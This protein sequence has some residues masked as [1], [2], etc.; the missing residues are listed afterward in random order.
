MNPGNIEEQY[1]KKK[2][3]INKIDKNFLTQFQQR[4]SIDQ[5]N[6]THERKQQK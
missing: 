3:F 5:E 2:Y 1:S 4:Q 6:A